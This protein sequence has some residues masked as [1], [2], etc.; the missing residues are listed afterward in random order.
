LDNFARISA[1]R[2]HLC[3]EYRIDLLSVHYPGPSESE[4]LRIR[5]WDAIVQEAEEVLSVTE[6]V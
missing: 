1:G 3:L 2:T 6:G 5:S 4:E